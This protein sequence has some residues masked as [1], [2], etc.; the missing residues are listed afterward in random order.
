MNQ[1]VEVYT[2][3]MNLK[4]IFSQKELH[5]RQLRWLEIVAN[6]YLDIQNHPKKA[7]IVPNALSRKPMAMYQTRQKEIIGDIERLELEVVLP[8]LTVQFME[9]QFRFTLIDRIK[10]V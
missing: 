2:D 7:N 4:Y 9:L 10:E 6:F 3:H 8:G 5:M 1:R